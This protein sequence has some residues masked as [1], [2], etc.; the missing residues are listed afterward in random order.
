MRV[1]KMSIS[2]RR[3]VAEQ[4]M[5]HENAVR[6]LRR[7][8]G[9]SVDVLAPKVGYKPQAFRRIERGEVRLRT[10]V[11]QK[12]AAELGVSMGEVMGR[13]EDD[14]MEKENMCRVTVTVE[15][16]G[17]DQA[18]YKTHVLST[19]DPRWKLLFTFL[20]VPGFKP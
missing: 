16:P 17:G 6:T 3:T 18:N 20:E 15:Q 10:D 1:T 9:L 14:P 8:A 5:L 7:E 19:D 13:S 11:A 2:R 12:I 4:E